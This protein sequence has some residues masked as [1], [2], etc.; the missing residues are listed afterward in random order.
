MW[1]KGNVRLFG[2]VLMRPSLPLLALVV[3]GTVL[4]VAGVAAA[5][6]SA[7][8]EG[9]E[10]PQPSWR[11]AGGDVPY[12]IERQ[13][14]V[15]GHAHSGDR[16]ELLQ[17][18]G[19]SGHELLFSHDVGQPYVID[20]LMPTVWIQ[21]DRPGIQLLVRVALPRTIDP[22]TGKPLTALL[23]GSSYTTPGRWQQ[24]R[25]DNLTEQ[26]KQHTWTLRAQV[27][28]QVDPREAYVD[29]VLLNAYGGPG[30][31]TVWID[32]LELAGYAK[33]SAHEAPARSAAADGNNGAP[34][35]GSP[36]MPRSDANIRRRKIAMAGHVLMADDRPVF[37][38][39]IQYQGEP[40]KLLR[41]LGFNVVWLPNVP[42]PEM[43]SEANQLG[44]WL[45]TPPPLAP[46]G[47]GAGSS[48]TPS[49]IDP[50][51]DCVL[52][53]DLGH[54]LGPSQ[55]PAIQRWKEQIRASDNQSQRPF[56]CEPASALRPYSN[57]AQ[58]LLIGRS[59]LGS[60][61]QLN[62]YGTWVR[63]RP[64]L[65]VPGTPVWTTIQTQPSPTLQQQWQT[66]GV[67]QPLPNRFA[68]EQ[69]RLLV[70]TS[71]TAG[72]RGLL[73]E[74]NTSLVESD[75]DTRVRATT[76]ELLN[77]ELGLIEPWTAAG[78]FIAM[79]PSSEPGLVGALLQAERARILVPLWTE[80]G[81]QFVS[82]Q[83]AG[84]GTT[85]VV[86]GVPEGNDA[87]EIAPG[88]LRPVRSKRV[89]GGTRVTLD[90]FSLTSLILFTQDAMVVSDLTQRAVRIGQRAAQLQHDL[91]V[92]KLQMVE[93]TESR[94]PPRDSA[95]AQGGQ[96]LAD[97]RRNLQ[98]CDRLMATGG[99]KNCRDI[100]AYADR[101]M[102]PLRL[103]E[104][105]RWE[106]AVA[107]LG[108]PVASPASVCYATLP[109]HWRFLGRI[110]GAATG[111][112][113]LASGDFEDLGI[114]LQAGWHHFQ[115]PA[116]GVFSG[117]DLSPGC[118]HGGRYGLRLAARPQDA[119]NPPTMIESPPLWVTGP[120]V[121][122]QAGE[123]ICIQ[124]WVQIPAPITGSVDG[125]LIV[126]S[127]G[128]EALEERIGETTGW[129]QFTLYR[130]VP[131]SGQ[132]TVSF[133]LSGLGE[134][135]LDDV[136]VGPVG[137]STGATAPPTVPSS[138]P[139]SNGAMTAPMAQTLPPVHSA[140]GP[141]QQPSPP[142]R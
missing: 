27:G 73:F 16:C 51:Y 4:A 97:A 25:V 76:L 41:Q 63:Q 33:R 90:E 19:S 125:L 12:R 69:I 126:D 24:L 119:K 61:L 50:A 83:A 77:L 114:M 58:L 20:E 3:L 13:E 59:P 45:V 79:V 135:W 38:R 35:S 40:L 36:D 66:M 47:A 72:S 120:K 53:W 116:P 37:P 7:W 54:G 32:D 84:N 2:A 103:L 141:F 113:R 68:S 78:S 67:E 93:Q 11:L 123:V 140:T 55:L 130:V 70:Y 18:S 94:M 122:V 39:V 71:V 44:L 128:G 86:P 57:I 111:E 1:P 26:L 42:K 105:A 6:G 52:A 106:S 30:T 34:V 9:F 101:A 121:N 23:R 8:S 137:P 46:D 60:S 28:P 5:D 107:P 115:H 14:R 74:S 62:D 81:S 82:G 100:F 85:F 117:A 112:N 95:A 22:R 88:G 124:G 43:I 21:S 15:Q 98:Q 29:V 142:G 17:I 49:K 134:A 99:L 133:A 10:G 138:V 87:Y 139:T 80:P 75:P 65:A 110:R 131:E 64:W 48:A 102:R 108:S 89:T 104:R 129:K 132:M 92:A 127:L 56:I 96:W 118:A 109:A 136:Y 31:T 91:A